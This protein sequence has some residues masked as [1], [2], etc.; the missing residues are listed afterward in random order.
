MTTTKH[1]ATPRRGVT[2]SLLITVFAAVVAIVVTCT[3]AFVSTAEAAPA[4]G[5]HNDPSAHFNWFDIYYKSKDV[6]GGTLEPGEEPMSPPFAMLLINFVAVLVIIRLVMIPGIRRY[7]SKRHIGIRE[8]LEEAGKLRADAEA[9]LTEYVDQIEKA[10][11]EIET[12]VTDIRRD[13]EAE[14]DRILTE[15]KEQAEAM[16]RETEERIN[17]EIER[18]RLELEREVVAVAVRVAEKL[19]QEKATANDQTEL[20]ETFI[21][22]VKDKASAQQEQV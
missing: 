11:K 17:A 15:A 1:R 5:G 7:V 14:K 2:R 6:N 22:D 8:A 16:K 3:A 10:E 18:A 9:T 4:G 21:A 12:M 20:V 19:I 13:A